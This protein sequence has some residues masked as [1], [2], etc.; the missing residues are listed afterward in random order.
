[1]GQSLGSSP[2]SGTISPSFLEHPLASFRSY[3]KLLFL[4]RLWG[5]PG[6]QL[7]I[8]HF[9][10][11]KCFHSHR[12]KPRFKD[13][14]G[15]KAKTLPGPPSSALRQA[16][17]GPCYP[18]SLVIHLVGPSVRSQGAWGCKQHSPHAPES[19]CSLS[20]RLPPGWLSFFPC[21]PK[22]GQRPGINLD[23]SFSFPLHRHPLP[24]IQ[25]ITKSYPPYLL[26][27]LKP[28]C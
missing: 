21:L 15:K 24:P 5:V 14:R 23:P 28:N 27:L 26:Q 6:K 12:V 16:V 20:P 18:V 4:G 11:V 17:R 7:V 8:F 10:T 9:Q 25:S 2:A 1:M 3:A 22:T 13:W 19:L